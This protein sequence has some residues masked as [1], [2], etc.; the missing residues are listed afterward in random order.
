M[1]KNVIIS[2]ADMTSSVYIGSKDKSM[3]FFGELPTEGWGDI[4]L[5]PE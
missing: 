3:L 4:I 1:G 2:E 5:T